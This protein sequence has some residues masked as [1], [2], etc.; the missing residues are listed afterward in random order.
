MNPKED[1]SFVYGLFLVLFLLVIIC[2]IFIGMF[3]YKSNLMKI[4]GFKSEYAQ[5][6]YDDLYLEFNEPQT[7]MNKSGGYVI[8]NDVKSNYNNM[9]YKKIVL[10]DESIAHNQPFLHCDFLYATIPVY[11]PDGITDPQS[12][13]LAIDDT[14][15]LI[16]QILNVSLSVTYDHLKRE[17][18]SRCHFMGANVVTLWLCMKILNDPL[19][20]SLYYDKY[21]DT[22]FSMMGNRDL[23]NRT[24]NELATMLYDNNIKYSSFFNNQPCK[25]SFKAGI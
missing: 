13:K 15:N 12:S 19:N 9:V 16:P 24:S 5:K 22:V 3:Y 23:Y 17:L 20:S 25:Y 2:M 10:A 7:V 8:W 11:I 18:T 1:N 14:K 6:R 21:Q 4:S